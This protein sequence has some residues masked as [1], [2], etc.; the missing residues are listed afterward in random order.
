M[1]P[2]TGR[3]SWPELK[4]NPPSSKKNRS[5]ICPPG[6]EFPP[7]RLSIL[8]RQVDQNSNTGTEIPPHHL[9]FGSSFW[10]FKNM[11]HPPSAGLK[12]L[13]AA[14]INVLETHEAGLAQPEVQEA[15]ARQNLQIVLQSYPSSVQ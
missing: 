15:I 2:S 14:G 7:G 13:P 3:P 11:C 9:L 8:S 12:R 5:P 1:M 4:E 10:G 6:L